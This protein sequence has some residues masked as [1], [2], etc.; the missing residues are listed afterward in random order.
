LRLLC[1]TSDNRT[2]IR[3]AARARCRAM[4]REQVARSTTRDFE[5]LKSGMALPPDFLTSITR[6]AINLL[7]VRRYEGKIVL[8][9][10]AQDAAAAAEDFARERVVGFD[11]ETRPAF[12]VGQKYPPALAQV[13]TGRAVYLFPLQKTDFAG[14]LRAL[15]ES[16][17]LKAGVGIGD[18]LKS[19]REVFPFEIQNSCDLGAAARSHG[20]E[21][22]GVRALAALF[23]GFRV[24]KGTKT[25]NWAARQLS[26]QQVAYAATDA[27][28]CREL[29]LKFE[30][31]Q[32]V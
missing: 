7:P 19:L 12:Q 28:A 17:T 26:P 15:M 5:G 29:Y 13:A 32:L 2:F 11:T 6:D 20:I 23:L 21:R 3:A 24:P 25:S 9:A 16:R 8:V 4:L 18:D 1:G 14:V 30:Q 22:S 27:W 31:M 10:G